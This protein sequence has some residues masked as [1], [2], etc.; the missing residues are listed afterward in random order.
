[1][2]H[3]ANHLN[4]TL[5]SQEQNLED[6]LWEDACLTLDIIA[7]MAAKGIA[8][9]PPSLRIK[10]HAGPV[11][12]A[13]MQR[14]ENNISKAYFH[15][16]PVGIDEQ[17]LIGGLDLTATL[18]AGKR[19]ASKG[20]L[21][22]SH[23][24][25]LVMP[26]ANL[27]TSE[28]ISQ[29]TAAMD[30]GHVK[31]ERDG[32]ST[33]DDARFGLI[34]FDESGEGDQA[35]SESL[36]DRI[37]FHLDLT[38]ISYRV[39]QKQTNENSLEP[40]QSAVCEGNIVEELCALG[41]S[42][43]LTSMRPVQQA[44]NV[45]ILHARLKGRQKVVQ[46]DVLASIRLSLLNRAKQLPQPPQD[47][48]EPEE[49]IEPEPPQEK[50]ENENENK[51]EQQSP[52]IED[53]P[54]EDMS[55]DAL[56]SEL[57]DGLLEQLAKSLNLH[58]QSLSQGRKGKSQYNNKRG[59]P[60]ASRRGQ[61]R[62]GQSLDLMATLRAATPWQKMRADE[63]AA[64]HSKNRIHIRAQDFHIRRFKQN[65][66]TSTIFVVD[67]SGST[68]LNRL[69]EAK[70]AIEGLLAEGYARRDHVALVSFRKREA[71]V[72]LSPTRSLVRAKKSLASL[73]G[74]GGTPLASGLQSAFLI[75]AEE[76]RNGRRVSIVIITDGSANVALDGT[77]GRAQAMEDALKM[78]QVIAQSQMPCMVVDV[79]RIPNPKARTLSEN[80]NA[81]YIPMP[82]V[83][84]KNLSD[85]VKARR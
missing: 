29:I 60:V 2:V 10:A 75:G 61:L 30:H 80:L 48:E 21:A 57:P 40:A 4:H 35:L 85:A 24:E 25:I 62:S 33:K 56:A 53:K 32:V 39:L 51:D 19:I 71:E 81:N 70:G 52:E 74:G 63:Y 77:G 64:T 47:I 18:E 13:L 42:F 23:N 36:C 9:N 12:E 44:L 55:I 79:S 68:A 20:L 76:I 58:S 11:R 72:L 73:P 43:G 38:P 45:A 31:V 83:S 34:V 14:L 26:M 17:K 1:M 27:M 82:F 8:N 54:L 69:G 46:E 5:I 16:M 15:K 49:P 37:M 6:T 7:L 59:R 41:L 3:E 66:Q 78:A 50:N 22:R 67:A 84:S 28:I 65:T